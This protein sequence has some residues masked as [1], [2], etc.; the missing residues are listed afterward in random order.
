MSLSIGSCRHFDWLTTSVGPPIAKWLSLSVSPAV[1]AALAGAICA[2]K[3]TESKTP[4]QWNDGSMEA[5]LRRRP[6][7]LGELPHAAFDAVAHHSVT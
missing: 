1:P 5:G 2:S 6:A 7:T 3:S 4:S